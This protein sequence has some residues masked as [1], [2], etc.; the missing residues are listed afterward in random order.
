MRGIEES[1][2][3]GLDGTIGAE[4]G[5]GR[6]ILAEADTVL[7]LSE[8]PFERVVG[9]HAGDTEVQVQRQAWIELESQR[10]VGRFTSLDSEWLWWRWLAAMKEAC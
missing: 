7:V 5:R 2:S 3:H 10:R 6:P 9:K 1:G 4:G 8:E